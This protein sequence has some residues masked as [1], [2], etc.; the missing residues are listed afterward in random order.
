MNDGLLEVWKNGVKVYSRLNAPIGYNDK[1]GPFFKMGIY[2]GQWEKLAEDGSQLDA[3]DHRVIY[4][5]EFKM[6]D[7]RGSYELVA[8]AGNVQQPL[9]PSSVIVQ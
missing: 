5:D 7:E 1:T 8:P 3:V 2:K 6:A 4:H 9:P